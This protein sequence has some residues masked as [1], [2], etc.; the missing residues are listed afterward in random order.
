M[1]SKERVLTAIRHCEP[2]SVPI[3][4][5]GIDH[6][7][8][9]RILGRHTYWRNRKDTTLALWQ[10]RRDEL[11]EGLKRDCVDIVN[12][13]DYDI[14]TVELVPPKGYK[15]ADI[16]RQ[17][18]DGEWQDS[19]GT[20]YQYAASND[21]IMQMTSPPEKYQFTD[22][23][24]DAICNSAANVDESEFEL[25]DHVC[26]KFNG[27]K[28]ILFRGIN[29]YENILG[30]FGGDQTHQLV[31]TA[32]DRDQIKKAGEA[33]FARVL[34]LI[35]C[36][37]KRGITIVMCG[38]DFGGSNGCL[39]SPASI[40]ELFM[41]FLK[42]FC[43]E[44]TAANMIPFLHCCGNV[45]DIMDDFVAAGFKGYQSIQA[46]AGMDTARVKKLYGDKITLWTGVQCE[47]LIEK[48]VAETRKE[49]VRS[50]EICM[51]GGGFIFG[52][53]NSVQFGAKTENYLAALEMV[54][55]LGKY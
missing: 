46:S 6:D 37:K 40:R 34:Y 9:S 27:T 35:D 14:V 22:A 4:E 10:G 48:S 30:M 52:S 20:V 8:V 51:P 23:D 49:A 31:M 55:T 24:L 26:E 2:D 28:A 25:I 5:W 21:S 43:D 45:W 47:T 53:T 39:I 29:L 12:A 3:G 32:T 50:L 13:L 16:P 7:H 54:K 41:P 15:V 17:I 11:V 19:K 42:Q 38:Q 44:V 36:C 1:N 33:M 18:A